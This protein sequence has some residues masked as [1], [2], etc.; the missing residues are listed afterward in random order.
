MGAS[1]DAV[2]KELANP[3]ATVAIGT[4]LDERANRHKGN[5]GRAGP[6]LAPVSDHRP[7]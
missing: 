7:D 6:R 2:A 4:Y 5:H 3:T 1:L